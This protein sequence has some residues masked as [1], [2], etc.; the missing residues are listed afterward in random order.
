M[1]NI[2]ENMATALEV[3]PESFASVTMLYVDVEVNQT[4]IKAFVDSGAQTTV[5]SR[6]CAEKCG[7]MRLVDPRFAGVAVGVGQARILGRVHLAPIKI[8]SQIYNCTFTVLDSQTHEMDLLLGL[9]M[10]KK[11]QMVIDLKKNCLHIGDGD[12]EESVEF[13]PENALPPH[14][15]GH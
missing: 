11:H 14:A 8:G 5:V 13:L 3:S 12:H 7:I 10:M 9:D 6:Q 15:R 2:Q 4:P 1:E